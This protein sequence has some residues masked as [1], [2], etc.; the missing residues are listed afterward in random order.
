MNTLSGKNFRTVVAAVLMLLMTGSVLTTADDIGAEVS[1]VGQGLVSVAIPVDTPQIEKAELGHEIFVEGFGRLLVPGKPNL[2]SKIFAVA[3]P[4]GAE[5]AELTFETAEGVV[6]PGTYNVAPAPLPRVIGQEDPL[7]YAEEQRRY[8]Q[9]YN[10]VYGSDVAYPQ[11]VVEFV[12]TAGYRKYNLVDVRVTPFTYHPTS[13]QLTYY[14]EIIVH[15]HYRMPAQPRAAMVDN[16]TR[17]ERIAEGII[18]NYDEATAWYPGGGHGGRGLHDFVII[19]LDSLTSS[20]T[21]LVNWEGGKGRSVE[22][23]TT[24]W[25]N[26]NYS[27]YDLA[28]RMRNFLRDKYP[29]ADWGI[30]DVL[31]VGHYDD[32]P[33]RRCAQNTGYGQP[34]TDLY[35]AELSLP[36]SASWDANGNHQYGEDS[37]PIDFYS[38]VNVGRIPWSQPDTVLHVCQKS[39]AYEQTDDPAF[40]KNILLLGAFFWPDTDNAV[41]M[42]R[43]VD[44]PWMADWTMTR[45]YEQ[46]QSGYGMDY[47][48]S[49][50]NVQTVWSAGSYAFVDWAGHGSPTACY[51]YYP[52]QAFVD[53]ATCSY[54]NDNYPAIIFADACSNSDT[55]S[56]NI[57]QAML[58]QGGVGF[59]GATKVAYGMPGWSGPMS[60][61]S[62]SLDYFFTTSV[63]STDYTQGAGHQWSLRQMYTYGLWGN[64]KYEMFEW[65]ALWGN[66]DLGMG[67]TPV[68][69]ITFP[70]GL[71]EF[72]P[73]GEAT[74]IT[75]RIDEGA[76]EYVPD[77][78]TL[79]YRDDGGEFQTSPLVSQGGELYLA[80]LPPAYCEDTPEFYFSAEGTESGVIYQPAGAPDDTFTAEVGEFVVAFAENLDT[81]PG[82]TTQ[83]QW[84]FGQP[85]GGGGEYGGPD[86]TS[87]YTGNNVYGYNLNGDYPN[88]MPEYHLTS[89]AIDCTGLSN[90]RLRFWR[91][92]GVEQAAYDHAYIRVSNN[93]SNWTTVWQN[94]G[95]VAD[96]AWTQMDVDISA[97]ADD[98]PTVYLRW[99]MGTSDGGWKYCGWNLDDVELVYFG[100]EDEIPGDLDGD[101]CVDQV[102]LGILLADWNCTDGECPGDCDGDGDTDQ[103]D[104]GM[105]LAHWGEG[106]P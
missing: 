87:G 34:E 36:D 106:C 3:I 101:G 53:T 23:V 88:Y 7:V 81:N 75:V 47:N 64:V 79:Y 74:D 92:L 83:S 62:Q 1:A 19:T 51:E 100:C 48:L 65:G 84:A 102:D 21:P 60:G 50:S 86:P 98:Q 31:L 78:G 4:P 52:S 12:R 96:Y 82:W 55:D 20:V 16:L 33:M 15:V 43:K 68:L 58:A 104:L 5:F 46:G 13:G 42:E 59:L 67:G 39:A 57:G 9:N 93:G 95:E 89:T 29:T 91:W 45:M 40:K 71:P 49:Y 32:V 77:S 105:L 27:G 41:L 70:A 2:P 103:A 35:Y 72:L 6:L 8:E 24:S 76:E 17:T 94:S 99:T 26:S 69:T 10:A 61:S 97:V 56:F 66:P 14:P 18:L 11:D 28:E 63:T 54:L 80:T 37:D 22:V 85:T 90:V 25:I 73:P 44:Q 30:E 38:E